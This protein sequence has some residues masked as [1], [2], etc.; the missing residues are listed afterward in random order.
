[1]LE[2][3]V[4]MD[5]SEAPAKPMQIVSGSDDWSPTWPVGYSNVDRPMNT[6]ARKAC[7]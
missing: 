2:L 4:E 3:R 1:L 5:E 7:W 6:S